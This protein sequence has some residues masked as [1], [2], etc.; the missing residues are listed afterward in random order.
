VKGDGHSPGQSTVSDQPRSR[1][2]ILAAAKKVFA[3]NGFH[4][5]TIADVATEAQPP[6]GAVY[7]YFDSRDALFRALIAAEG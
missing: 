4:G 5:T 6:F 3:H 1:E 7:Q 2:D